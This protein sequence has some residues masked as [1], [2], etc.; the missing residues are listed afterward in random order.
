VVNAFRKR[1]SAMNLRKESPVAVGPAAQISAEDLR[2]LREVAIRAG[3]PERV[4]GAVA[5]RSLASMRRNE[6]AKLVRIY[7]DLPVSVQASE[8]DV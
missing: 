6:I 2:L 7:Y 4:L 5:I 1:V 3:I 8:V